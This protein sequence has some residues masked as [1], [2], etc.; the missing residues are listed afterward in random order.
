MHSIQ[1]VDFTLINLRFEYVTMHARI[2]ESMD[3][4]HIMFPYL[5]ETFLIKSYYNAV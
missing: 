3:L 1:Q 4:I 5:I 2:I